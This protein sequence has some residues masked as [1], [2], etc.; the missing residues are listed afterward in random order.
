[1]EAAKQ[2]C[3][4]PA[5]VGCEDAY[6]DAAG[7]YQAAA[8]GEAEVWNAMPAPLE[9][10]G[11]PKA[12]FTQVVCGRWHCVALDA[13]GAVLVHCEAGQSRSATVVIAAL[14]ANIGQLVGDGMATAI[15]RTGEDVDEDV[16]E[17]TTGLSF[18]DALAF[19]RAQRPQVRPNDGFLECL[20]RAAWMPLGE[21]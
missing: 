20:Q 16:D 7:G 6:A 13:T 1:M 11:A 5:T 15:M 21:S 17:P 4:V 18:S 8:G 3:G 9:E 2:Q 14:M 12:R 19:V 10:W